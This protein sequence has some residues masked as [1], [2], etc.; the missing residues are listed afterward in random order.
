MCDSPE[1]P[2]QSL[3]LA[4]SRKFSKLSSGPHWPITSVITVNIINVKLSCWQYE[5]CVVP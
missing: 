5:C 1:A 2:E 3:G 4:E